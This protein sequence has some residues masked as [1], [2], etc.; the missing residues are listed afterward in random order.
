VADLPAPAT[1]RLCTN[2]PPCVA[3]WLS[4]RHHPWYLSAPF[5]VVG[6]GRSASIPVTLRVTRGGRTHVSSVTV[7]VVQD[8]VP[9][10][11]V[12]GGWG[13]AI[14]DTDGNLVPRPP[15]D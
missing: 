9:G 1:L 10:C 5:R 7:R 2:Q 4:R 12:Y 6:D 15:G 3:T 14:A 11:G 8:I 13:R